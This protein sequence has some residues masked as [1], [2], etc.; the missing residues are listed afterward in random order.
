[1]FRTTTRSNAGLRPQKRGFRSR[2]SCDVVL[3][4]LST[5][6]PL[7]APTEPG[8][9]NHFSALSAFAAFAPSS[10]P[11]CFASFE[12]T[13]PSDVLA[14]I[15]GIAVFGAFEVRTTPYFPAARTVTPPSRND[16]LP[17]RL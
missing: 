5:Y 6:G 14:T 10:S 2:T 7:P 15:A 1:M 17:L 13:I 11:C 3:Y 9:L 16:G 12:L 8:E 4:C